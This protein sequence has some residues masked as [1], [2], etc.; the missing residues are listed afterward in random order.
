MTNSKTAKTENWRPIPGYEGFYEVSDLGNVR[1]LRRVVSGKTYQGRPI[2]ACRVSDGRPGVKLYRGGAATRK[3]FGV[4]RIVALAFLGEPPDPRMEVCHNDGD[5]LNNALSNLRWDTRSNNALDTVRHGKHHIANKTA[6]GNGHDYTEANTV[7]QVVRRCRA[8]A[9]A[10]NAKN[11]LRRQR[12][13]GELDLTDYD[14]GRDCD[15]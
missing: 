6:C 9:D 13:R 3:N 1:S 14:A 11:R 7:W 10:T 15:G 8:C 12:A 2:K 4:H 5:R